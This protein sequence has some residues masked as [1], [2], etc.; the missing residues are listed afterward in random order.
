MKITRIIIDVLA[1]AS[2]AFL[3]IVW[4]GTTLSMES[5]GWFNRYKLQKT[6]LA[7]Y[8]VVTVIGEDIDDPSSFGSDSD[9][10]LFSS[11]FLSPA[12]GIIIYILSLLQIFPWLFC[13]FIVFVT[14]PLFSE[15]HNKIYTKIDGPY[16]ISYIL[17]WWNILLTAGLYL[18]SNGD[19]FNYQKYV[20]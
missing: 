10:E 16:I 7:S 14:S 18:A 4:L 6:N 8:S 13:I 5:D 3:F 12:Y 1:L 20:N 11:K 17:L 9:T 19:F 15:S 2:S